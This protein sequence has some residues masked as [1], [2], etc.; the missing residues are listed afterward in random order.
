M[1]VRHAEPSTEAV[2]TQ[3]AEDLQAHRHFYTFQVV[4]PWG[5]GG[6]ETEEAAVAEVIKARREHWASGAGRDRRY[7]E[8]G[9]RRILHVY[10]EDDSSY[11]SAPQEI[12]V[13]H[14]PLTEEEQAENHRRIVV[15]ER[16]TE[17]LYAR[18][19]AL[20]SGEGEGR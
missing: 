9:A 2:W 3:V 13:P 17:A 5:V 6:A 1:T 4:G 7:H 18:L 19:R 20:G 12:D 8:I 14:D 11:E 15:A 10:F 16:A